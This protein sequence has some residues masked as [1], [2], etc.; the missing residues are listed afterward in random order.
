MV[1]TA[2]QVAIAS[3]VTM[4][5]YHGSEGLPQETSDNVEVRWCN[6]SV[7]VDKVSTELLEVFVH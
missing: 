7:D 2:T 1:R 3:V 5:T 6:L 4:I